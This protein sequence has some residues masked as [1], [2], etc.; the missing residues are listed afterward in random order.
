[1]SEW[2]KSMKKEI[3]YDNKEYELSGEVLG[4]LTK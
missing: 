2:N 1:M 4:E 3:T